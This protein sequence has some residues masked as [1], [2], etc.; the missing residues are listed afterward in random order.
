[1]PWAAEQN[2]S[3]KAQLD[4][5][6]W[7]SLMTRYGLQAEGTITV[8]TCCTAHAKKAVGPIARAIYNSSSTSSVPP[9][10]WDCTF[11]HKIHVALDF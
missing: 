9:Q 11:V 2:C 7:L 4:Q 5:L 1:M 10:A 3:L 8:H 6:L